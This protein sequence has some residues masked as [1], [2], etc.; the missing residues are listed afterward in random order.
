MESCFR[1]IKKIKT[2][3]KTSWYC[4]G[5]HLKLKHFLIIFI[6]IFLCNVIFVWFLHPWQWKKNYFIKSQWICLELKNENKK[7]FLDVRSKPCRIGSLLPDRDF[8]IQ[9]FLLFL[10]LEI[11]RQIMLLL[12]PFQLHCWKHKLYEW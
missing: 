5:K 2:N 4:K 12:L 7:S 9:G 6:S 3:K 10:V 8:F 1:M 11:S